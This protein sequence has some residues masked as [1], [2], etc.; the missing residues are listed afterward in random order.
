MC[1]LKSAN[2]AVWRV[3]ESQFVADGRGFEVLRGLVKALRGSG[4]CSSLC[5]SYA[6]AKEG[7][8]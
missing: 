5:S 3:R 7:R 1:E 6:Q 8:S 4:G 2:F